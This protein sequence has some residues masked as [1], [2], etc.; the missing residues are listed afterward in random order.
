MPNPGLPH[1]LYKT[2]IVIWSEYD[3]QDVEL[4]DLARDATSG[5]AFCDKQKTVFITDQGKFPDT[6]F[7]GVE[8]G[9]EEEGAMAGWDGDEEDD[10]D[11]R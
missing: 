11:G 1:G 2:T 9:A 5:E 4:E 3:P 10:D 7:F 8:D 6:E